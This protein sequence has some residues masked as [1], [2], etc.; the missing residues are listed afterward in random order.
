MPDLVREAAGEEEQGEPEPFH[1]I[2]T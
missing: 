1:F 2:K